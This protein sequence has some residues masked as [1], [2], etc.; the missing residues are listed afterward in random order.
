MRN[1]EQLINNAPS[2][3]MYIDRVGGE[4]VYSDDD[5]FAPVNNIDNIRNWNDLKFCETF[6][7]VRV[8][9]QQH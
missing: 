8:I 1:D 7:K 9:C 2:W 3:A 5:K 6:E 4:L